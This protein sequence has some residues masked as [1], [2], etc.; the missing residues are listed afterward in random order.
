MLRLSSFLI[1]GYD[2]NNIPF[3]SAS[4]ENIFTLSCPAIFQVLYCLKLFTLW[5]TT[6]LPGDKFGQYV[7]ETDHIP[8]DKF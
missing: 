6:K 1:I 4:L 3:V 2:I 8:T 7:A 5:F